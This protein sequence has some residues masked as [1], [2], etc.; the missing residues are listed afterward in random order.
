MLSVDFLRVVEL[1]GITLNL[2][3]LSV[4]MQSY[5]KQSITIL[6]VLLGNGDNA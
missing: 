1:S 6:R 3:K 4:S 5:V 2:I